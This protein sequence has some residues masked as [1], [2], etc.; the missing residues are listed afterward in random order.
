MVDVR[1][2]VTYRKLPQCFCKTLQRKVNGRL[3]QYGSGPEKWGVHD[4]YSP[5]DKEKHAGRQ[6]LDQSRFEVTFGI[7]RVVPCEFL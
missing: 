5:T 1:D 6:D 2:F 7:L 3:V 4:L